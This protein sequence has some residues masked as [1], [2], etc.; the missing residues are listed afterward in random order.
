ML[1]NLDLATDLVKHHLML[2]KINVADCISNTVC[3]VW[4]SFYF[5]RCK[6]KKLTSKSTL[7]SLFHTATWRRSRSYMKSLL[8]K[9]IWNI[10]LRNL[11]SLYWLGYVFLWYSSFWDMQPFKIIKHCDVLED[12]EIAK[13]AERKQQGEMIYSLQCNYSIIKGSTSVSLLLQ[14]LRLASCK[15]LLQI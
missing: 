10:L 13:Q 15:P 3:R 2:H 1:I 6:K 12:H 14:L 11:Q 9:I 7:I 5:I 4:F 8:I